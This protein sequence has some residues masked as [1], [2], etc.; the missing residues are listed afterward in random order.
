[1]NRAE[2]FQGLDLELWDMNGRRLIQAA[3]ELAKLGHA[4]QKRDDGDRYFNH[5]R[6][7]A[8]LMVKFS[9]ASWKELCAALLH[10]GLEDT[11]IPDIVYI[12]TFG[13]DV[14]RWIEILSKSVPRID[15]LT[16]CVTGYVKKTL[17]DYFKELM[18]SPKEV[19]AIKCCDR[20]HNLRT[21]G[22]RS[23]KKKREQIEETQKY[24]LPLAD[25]TNRAIGEAI[26]FEITLIE[27][28]L[29]AKA[30]QIV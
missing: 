21:I 8:R 25:A 28:E 14:Y 30:S 20:L 7:V 4:K 23:A 22:S 9:Y 2:F 17:E 24:I 10:D 15:P 3:Y 19:R 29:L 18:R 26:R 5:P 27:A 1:M 6:D 12:Q 16:G 13:P 11:Y